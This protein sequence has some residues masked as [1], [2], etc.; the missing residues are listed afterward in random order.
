M[1]IRDL[2]GVGDVQADHPRI[3]ALLQGVALIFENVHE[4]AQLSAAL[5][6]LEPDS[7]KI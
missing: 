1:K 6:P 5:E 2:V 3:D 7:S 4:H